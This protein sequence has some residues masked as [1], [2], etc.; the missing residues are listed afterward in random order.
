MSFRGIIHLLTIPFAVLIIT[1][2]VFSKDNADQ[3]PLMKEVV[4][5]WFATDDVDYYE[6]FIAEGREVRL[7][8]IIPNKK[9]KELLSAST[10]MDIKKPI[11][12]C[13]RSNGSNG[14]SGTTFAPLNGPAD[15][16]RLS[17]YQEEDSY[18]VYPI[19]EKSGYRLFK[20]QDNNL[21][22][23]EKAIYYEI[24]WYGSMKFTEL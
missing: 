22:G 15:V 20:P 10:F 5:S 21:A 2:I 1:W 8:K 23:W 12:L 6:M 14:I 24:T 9:E 16:D 3:E 11:L 17:Y 7:L 4:F 18:F 13:L 19:D